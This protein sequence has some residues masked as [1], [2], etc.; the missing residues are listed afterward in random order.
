M[1][2]SDF[3]NRS[4]EFHLTFPQKQFTEESKKKIIDNLNLAYS[5]GMA[6]TCIEIANNEKN[7]D[8]YTSC[9]NTVLIVSDGSAV[10]GLGNLGPAAVKP[11]LEAKASLLKIFGG[12]DSM[13][14]C[15]DHRNASSDA[16]NI[17][18]IVSAIQS[19]HTGFKAIFLED[20]SAPR[21]FK[22]EQD[23]QKLLN[24]PVFHDDQ[25]GTAIV[26]CAAMLN[27]L[28]KTN[29]E[30]KDVKVV[31]IGA[32]AAGIASL[33]LMKDFGIKNIILFDSKGP[34]THNRFENKYKKTFAS[35]FDGNIA[36]ALN[37]A[38]IFLGTSAADS[39]DPESLIN[40]NANP[41]VLALAN[42][43][44]DVN[45]DKLSKH[46]QD[47]FI[48]TGS[49]E[50]EN[51]VNNLLCFPFFFRFLI[52]FDIKVINKRLKTSMSKAI[53][54][55]LQ[56]T[57]SKPMQLLPNIKNQWLRY[58]IPLL[59]AKNMSRVYPPKLIRD[60]IFLQFLGKKI[61]HSSY[62]RFEEETEVSNIYNKIL[63][64][65]GLEENVS[66][67][68]Y[69]LNKDRSYKILIFLDNNDFICVSEKPLPQFLLRICKLTCKSVSDIHINMTMIGGYENDTLYLDYNSNLESLL[70]LSMVYA[71]KL[72]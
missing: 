19:I 1:S 50:H 65:M 33:K 38:D 34:I 35:N 22:I 56:L 27:W 61:D 58:Y 18:N 23:L 28:S 72:N 14:V 13:H 57:K 40:M 71:D 64:E 37:G 36:T 9:K 46:R 70:A 67:K 51:Q 20:I 44:P 60:K 6:Y 3:K 12:V 55:C 17:K 26:V 41:L 69:P 21:C 49:A 54:Q 43:V 53:A 25:H 15:I 59:T 45:V 11:V 4:L 42:P 31:A 8:L 29:R 63:F 66:K 16:I 47:A 62:C 5:P 68:I 10:I 2:N 24:I 39:V 30:A 52:D 32:G 48:C 7:I